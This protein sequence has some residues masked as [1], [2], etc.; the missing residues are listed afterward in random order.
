MP[1]FTFKE[2]KTVM[3]MEKK[4]SGVSAKQKRTA[5]NHNGNTKRLLARLGVTDDESDRFLSLC[6]TLEVGRFELKKSSLQTLFG[7]CETDRIHRSRDN[8]S[9]DEEDISTER[10]V[11]GGGSGIG[12]ARFLRSAKEYETASENSTANRKRI[13]EGHASGTRFFYFITLTVGTHNFTA[14]VS[15]CKSDSVHLCLSPGVQHS[16]NSKVQDRLADLM[17]MT[18]YFVVRY[19][20]TT[21]QKEIAAAAA[22]TSSIS[23]WNARNSDNS[24]YPV[25]TIQHLPKPGSTSS[26]PESGWY[27]IMKEKIN[28]GDNPYAR[29]LSIA[30]CCNIW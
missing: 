15:K 27:K 2:A 29:R 19:I 9:S 6:A 16:A 22:A 26:S 12:R 28:R 24:R 1:K 8:Y 5:D 23:Q 18:V 17:I 4:K 30:Y 7:D 3:Q 21:L 14:K 13:Q 25:I 11:C 20:Y 10:N